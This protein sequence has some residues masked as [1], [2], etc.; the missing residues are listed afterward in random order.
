MQAA[1]A[2]INDQLDTLLA[3]G[4]QMLAVARDGDWDRAG[5]LQAKCLGLAEDL[6]DKPVAAADATAVVTAVSE[7]MELHREVT[8][9]CRDSRDAAMQ[10]LDSLKQG[11]QAVTEYSSNVD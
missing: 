3:I 5:E 4:R 10:G 11:R 6:F 7:V 2:T 8:V 9:L 1:S